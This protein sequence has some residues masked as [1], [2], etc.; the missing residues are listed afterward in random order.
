MRCLRLTTLG[1]ATEYL[2]PGSGMRFWLH[3]TG[4]TRIAFPTGGN[5]IVCAET[6]EELEAQLEQIDELVRIEGMESLL[7]RL[8][9]IRGRMP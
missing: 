2:L 1:G 3:K 8:E 6:P 9:S 5:W 4:E 7:E